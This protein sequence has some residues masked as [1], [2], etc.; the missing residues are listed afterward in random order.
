VICS[1]LC[2]PVLYKHTSAYSK[3]REHFGPEVWVI[4]DQAGRG[5]EDFQGQYTEP[6]YVSVNVDAHIYQ[7]AYSHQT[8]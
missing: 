6:D 5:L 3:L 4:M 1:C 2:R 7:V 8:L